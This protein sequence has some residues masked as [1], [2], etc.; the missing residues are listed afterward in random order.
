MNIS[1][2]TEIFKCSRASIFTAGAMVQSRVL[3]KPVVLSQ[4]ARQLQ[5]HR[6]SFAR[7]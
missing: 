5:R 6:S 7:I 4:A 2:S 3:C 1:S